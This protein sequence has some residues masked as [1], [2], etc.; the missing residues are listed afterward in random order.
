MVCN[1]KH[2]LPVQPLQ[3]RAGSGGVGVG[4]GGSKAM[5]LKGHWAAKP[6]L[7]KVCCST[8]A[9]SRILAYT[10]AESFFLSSNCLSTAR[11]RA[12]RK[13]SMVTVGA[14]R[15]HAITRGARLMA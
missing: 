14:C 9:A 10:Y 6:C 11:D 4:S 2:H 13:P 1:R 3:G 7:S 5:T 8:E 12:C 15:A